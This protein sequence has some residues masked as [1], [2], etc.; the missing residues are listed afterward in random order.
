MRAG[1]STGGRR[2]SDETYSSSRAEDEAV[3]GSNRAGI[4]Q[5]G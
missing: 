2:R 1:Q 4:V 3:V 5:V